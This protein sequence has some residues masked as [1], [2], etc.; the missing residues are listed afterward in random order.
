MDIIAEPEVT[1]APA[2]SIGRSII[3]LLLIALAIAVGFTAM[4][5]FGIMAESAKRELGLSDTALA[6]IQG[7]GAA[8]PGA[9]ARAAAGA[10]AGSL[11]V[12]A[13]IYAVNALSFL[14][15][16]VALLLMRTNTARSR[17]SSPSP[18]RLATIGVSAC[19]RV[20]GMV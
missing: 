8:L 12:I 5:S 18:C 17:L 7:G 1:T 13:G 10:Q 14:A 20:V 16:I 6:L 4:Q 19:T 3:A 15:V 9:A 2:P 11:P